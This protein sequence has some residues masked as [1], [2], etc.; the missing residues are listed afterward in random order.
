MINALIIDDEQHC[1]DA[2]VA[3]LTK[4]CN[5][6]KIL[7]TCNSAKEGILSI[8]KLKPQLVFLDVEMPWMNGFEMLEVL[9]EI[10]FSIIFTTAYDKFA[11]KAFRISAI[12]YL[13]KPVDATDLITAVRKAEEKIVSDLGINNIENLLHNI[14]Q[15]AQEQKI[16]L[17]NSD[18]YAFAHVDSILYCSA[19]GAYTK[20][21]LK[22]KMPLLISR[23]LG[24]IEEM[25]PSE[26]FL[27]IHHSTIVNLNAITHY[28]RTDGGYVTI[29]TKE[30]LMVSK[31]RKEVL[32]QHLGLK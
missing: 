5:N 28:S 7:G 12:D 25:L 14:H 31:A 29:T 24:D 4:N 18:G 19:E 13:L 9:P 17:P 8:R 23:T 32:L 2:L 27:R 20:V 1:I 11:A 10:N 16:A 21:V 26:I 15:P 3:D 22:D 6:V 30:K